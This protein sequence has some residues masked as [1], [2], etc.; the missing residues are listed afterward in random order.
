[1]IVQQKQLKPAEVF[2]SSTLSISEEQAIKNNFHSSHLQAAGG[3][4]GGK[5]RK[6]SS[7][8]QTKG[9]GV[10]MTGNKVSLILDVTVYA[11]EQ[12][13]RRCLRLAGLARAP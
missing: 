11:A 10:T 4:S 1:M 12:E 3:V 7:N 5:L 6:T 8:V 9:S 2:S 13:K